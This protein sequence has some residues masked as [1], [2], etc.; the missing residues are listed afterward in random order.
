[1]PWTSNH[2][3]W[4]V[5]TGERLKTVDGTD[6]EVEDFQHENNDTAKGNVDSQNHTS[7]EV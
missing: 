1:M 6:V 7:G 2:A 4:L 3:K 5:D